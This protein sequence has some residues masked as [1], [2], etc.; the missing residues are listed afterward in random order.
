LTVNTITAG[1]DGRPEASLPRNLRRRLTRGTRKGPEIILARGA[2]THNPFSAITWSFLSHEAAHTGATSA[3]FTLRA[4]PE[5]GRADAFQR[6]W[7]PS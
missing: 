7:N 5:W 1:I 2:L 4:P 3:P 6:T